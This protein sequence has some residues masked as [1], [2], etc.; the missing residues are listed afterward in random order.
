MGWLTMYDAVS[1]E[2]LVKHLIADYNRHHSTGV[3]FKTVGNALRNN[4]LWLA[5]NGKMDGE[6][7]SRTFL[8]LFKLGYDKSMERWGYK[9]IEASMGPY[10]SDCPLKL[11]KL[12]SEECKTS[13]YSNFEERVKEYHARKAKESSGKRTANLEHGDQVFFNMGL[14]Y[15]GATGIWS[16]KV[17]HKYRRGVA[18][19][20]YG[21]DDDADGKNFCALGLLRVPNIR[22]WSKIVKA[23]GE[24]IELQKVTA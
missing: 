7:T 11:L 21:F 6:E 14:K 3:T 2:W 9:D 22:H 13:D 20:G 15:A 17:S 8:C 24:V 4:N 1:K 19:Y 16:I 18:G 23:N 10:E 5:I 12:V